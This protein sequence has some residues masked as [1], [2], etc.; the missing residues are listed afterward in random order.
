MV[1]G[2]CEFFVLK[3]K[4]ELERVMTVSGR[5]EKSAKMRGRFALENG[6]ISDDF[7]GFLRLRAALLLNLVEKA[8]GKDVVGRDSRETVSAFGGAL[9]R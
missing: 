3:Y 2:G 7:D 6:E 8:M 4:L 5:S 9:P 1:Q